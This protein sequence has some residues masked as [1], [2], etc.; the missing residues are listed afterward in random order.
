MKSE[1][2]YEGVMQEAEYTIDEMEAAG[3]I[4][5]TQRKQ[6][7]IET[8]KVL[9]NYRHGGIY[10]RNVALAAISIVA[11]AAEQRGCGIKCGNLKVG[12]VPYF[13]DF[14]GT[15]IGKDDFAISPKAV[16]GTKRLFMNSI[17]SSFGVNPII[18]YEQPRTKK[19]YH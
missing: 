18:M 1:I 11:D 4:T 13:A 8:H 2:G 10:H 6:F 7:V 19:L 5:P 15:D 17:Q 3:H 16:N 14:Y 9:Q 12:S